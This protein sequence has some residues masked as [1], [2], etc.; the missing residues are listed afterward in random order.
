MCSRDWDWPPRWR[1][2]VQIARRPSWM[3]PE[4]WDL[5]NIRGMGAC[6]TLP[7]CRR[8]IKMTSREVVAEL[9]LSPLPTNYTP[10]PSFETD[11]GESAPAGWVSQ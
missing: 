9:V 2:T 1:G 7:H 8:W 5:T 11:T 10:N 3:S 6:G 4:F